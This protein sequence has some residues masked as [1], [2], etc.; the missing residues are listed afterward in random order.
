MGEPLLDRLR[1]R[2]KTSQINYFS[3]P[4]EGAV[5]APDVAQ[6]DAERHLNLGLS[7]WDFS[8]GVLRWL[9]HGKQSLRFGI[10]ARPIC[11]CRFV[12]IRAY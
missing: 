6:I 12:Y 9:L 11:D 8:D 1:G 10:P 2:P 4:V 7:A 3:V 5:R